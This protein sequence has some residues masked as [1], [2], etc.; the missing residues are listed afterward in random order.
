MPAPEGKAG[1]IRVWLVSGLFFLILITGGTFLVLYVAFPE[2]AVPGWFPI[3]GMVLVAVPW[4]FWFLTCVYRCF[5]FRGDDEERQPIRASS[6]TPV[7]GGGRPTIITA[8]AVDNEIAVESPGGAR[9]V[10]FGNATVMGSADA[11]C[12]SGGPAAAQ[13]VQQRN[14]NVHSDDGSSHSE[15]PLSLSVT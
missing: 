15:V 1:D 2:N 13:T 6:V 9:R 8:P 10:R 5:L 11:A 3:A 7:G 12:S 4:F 14:G